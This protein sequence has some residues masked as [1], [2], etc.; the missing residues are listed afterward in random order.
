MIMSGEP[1][2][3]QSREA[4]AEAITELGIYGAPLRDIVED[5]LERADIGEWH[6]G[7]MACKNSHFVERLRSGGK[8]KS[9]TEFKVRSYIARNPVL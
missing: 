2:S 4:F 1:H 6:F 9:E 7:A 5:Y 3:R 8:F